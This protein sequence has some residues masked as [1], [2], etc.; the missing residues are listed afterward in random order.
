[1]NAKGRRR[2][3]PAAVAWPCDGARPI[4]ERQPR[5]RVSS[6]RVRQSPYVIPLVVSLGCSLSLGAQRPEPSCRCIRSEA[7]AHPHRLHVCVRPLLLKRPT[8]TRRLTCESLG[9]KQLQNCAPSPVASLQATHANDF[10]KRIILGIDIDIFD[11]KAGNDGHRTGAHIPHRCRN[12]EF[13]QRR[14]AAPCEPVNRQHPDSSLEEQSGCSLFVRN[15]AGTT[16]TSA[17]R[18]FQ[19]HASTL[20]RTVEQARHDVGIPKGFSGTLTIG[21]AGI[22]RPTTDSQYQ[23]A[24]SPAHSDQRRVWLFPD[25]DRAA[26]SCSQT[27]TRRQESTRILHARLCG[28][29]AG[30]RD[31]TCSPAPSS[32]MHRIAASKTMAKNG[33]RS[34]KGAIRTKR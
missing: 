31:A 16:L 9:E 30:Q 12:G 7:R 32:I 23:M 20:V 1:M 17:G 8:K 24:R 29:S 22:W 14:R 21:G 4:K 18:Q 2:H 26:A 28:L 13:H 5:R 10:D 15:K 11:T 25:A 33:A 19:R 3:H 27:A 34:T 6:P